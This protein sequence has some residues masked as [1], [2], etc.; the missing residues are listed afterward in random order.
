MKSLAWVQK[1]KL[2]VSACDGSWFKSSP[3]A[4]ARTASIGLMQCEFSGGENVGTG[5]L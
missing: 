3:V 2:E 5:V 4:Y 1:I